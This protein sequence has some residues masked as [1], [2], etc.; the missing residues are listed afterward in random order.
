MIKRFAIAAI[1]ALGLTA[2]SSAANAA[3]VGVTEID[4][5]DINVGNIIINYDST[6]TS[7]FSMTGGLLYQF[8]G[9]TLPDAFGLATISVDEDTFTV[10][11][12]GSTVLLTGNIL[13]FDTL[14]AAGF[15]VLAKATGGSLINDYLNLTVLRVG[16][17]THSGNTYTASGTG[18]VDIV[19]AIPLPAGILLLLSSG[20]ALVVA[21]RTA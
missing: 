3:F 6:D 17:G 13:D 1:A 18:T 4:P 14:T 2:A 9:L 15:N 12:S 11:D 16:N 21:R 8:T 7:T 5:P 10:T 20:A 19:A